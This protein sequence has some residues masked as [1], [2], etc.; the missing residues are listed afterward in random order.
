MSATSS[1]PDVLLS[2]PAQ[3][4]AGVVLLVEVIGVVCQFAQTTDPT[5]P[6]TY[7]TVDCAI[8]AAVAGAAA[9]LKP[10]H[11]VAPWLR[12][13]ATTGVIVSGLIYALVIAPASPTG[14]WIQ[15]WDDAL[16]RISTIVLHGVAPPLMLAF[17][18]TAPVLARGARI[19]EA[20]RWLVWPATYLT[21]MAAGAGVGVWT[22]P[23][24]FLRPGDSGWPAVLG[25]VVGMTFILLVISLGL[26]WLGGRVHRWVGRRSTAP[27]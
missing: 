9:L 25:A 16:V 19:A 24:P 23:Y 12:G 21:V 8:L 2:R 4:L 7:F 11:P 26:L 18:L 17:Y 10:A 5:P 3:V 27:A 22:I 6:L 13:T 20:A 1:R 14:T 15:P